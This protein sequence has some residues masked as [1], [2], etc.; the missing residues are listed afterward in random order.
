[1]FSSAWTG[2]SIIWTA[3][4]GR[5]TM[6]DTAVS[7]ALSLLGLFSET[8]SRL[9]LSEMATLS[10]LPKSTVL[11]LLTELEG[12]G[13]LAQD[14]DTKLWGIG[15]R[16]LQLAELFRADLALDRHAKQHMREL[17]ALSGEDVL[18][19]ISDRGQGMC[20]SRERSA[21]PLRFESPLG[22][23]Q[24]LYTGSSRKVILAHR[25]D[26]E[27]ERVI[28]QSGLKAY[29]TATITDPAA[30]RGELDRIRRRGYAFSTGERYQGVAG[31]AL[32]IFDGT[33]YAIAS[34]AV[35]GPESR[36]SRARAMRL[37]GSIAEAAQ[38][39]STKTVNDYRGRLH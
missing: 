2:R 19:T 16:P 26:D 33:S 25:P 6:T 8:R 35:V 7:K 23:H 20:I 11:R 24:P 10:R 28:E 22:S 39:I 21:Q 3:R 12:E 5:S 17:A 13:F 29:T 4:L 15:T 30:L 18:L 37:R 27:I 9:G 31:I 32:P 36:L 14:A 38:A 34:I 1:M